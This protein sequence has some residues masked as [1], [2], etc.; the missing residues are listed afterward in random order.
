MR[1]PWAGFATL[2]AVME[3]RSV[4]SSKWMPKAASLRN[5]RPRKPNQS[6]NPQGRPRAP[7]FSERDRH[8]II[9]AVAGALQSA[10]ITIPQN[11]HCGLIGARLHAGWAPGHQAGPY[12]ALPPTRAVPAGAWS[13]PSPS[14][15]SDAGCGGGRRRD[16]VTRVPPLDWYVRAGVSL[17]DSSIHSES[18]GP[19]P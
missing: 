12:W 2:G 3:Q 16:R 9:T 17:P 14:S 6:G 8:A 10:L 1:E 15:T 11:R 5:L 19:S 13:A 18:S 4:V 7:T